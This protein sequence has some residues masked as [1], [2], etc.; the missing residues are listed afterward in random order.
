MQVLARE[1]WV[2]LAGTERIQFSV[3]RLPAARC[4]RG[5]LKLVWTILLAQAVGHCAERER[6][7]VE[8]TGGCGG[9]HAVY[10]IRD[11]GAGLDLGISGKLSYVFERIQNQSSQPGIGVGLAIV[12]TGIGLAFV[13]GQRA[14]RQRP[15]LARI[16]GSVIAR[17]LPA[18]SAAAITVAG[19]V[20]AVGAMRGLA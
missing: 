8:V 5:M 13:F 18:V 1:A 11:N 3:G 7:R 15:F 9:E 16:G 2:S 14:L 20:I 17:A 6:P 4:H 12:L 19:L 10:G